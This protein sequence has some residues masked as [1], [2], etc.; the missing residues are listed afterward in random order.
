MSARE[1]RTGPASTDD[2]D[3]IPDHAEQ[4]P[5]HYHEAGTLEPEKRV[6]GGDHTDEEAWVEQSIR[7]DGV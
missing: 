1:H 5:R 3:N 6:R 4:V 7:R 2:E